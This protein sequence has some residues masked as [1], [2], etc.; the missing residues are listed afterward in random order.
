M[1]VY[2]VA[3]MEQEFGVTSLEVF[4]TLKEA[5]S[6]ARRMSSAEDE[7]EPPGEPDEEGRV[8]VVSNSY[9]TRYGY[10]TVVYVRDLKGDE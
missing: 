7:F 3:R 5:V 9:D 8:F 1:E 6:W 10:S 4:P 2:V